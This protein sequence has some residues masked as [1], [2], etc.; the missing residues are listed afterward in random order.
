MQPS[1][2]CSP[3]TTPLRTT[4]LDLRAAIIIDEYDKP[5]QTFVKRHID[6]LFGGN[7]VVICRKPLE[8]A[9]PPGVFVYERPRIR[10]DTLMRPGD[11]AARI[12]AAAGLRK[13]LR[14]NGVNIVLA[15]FGYC[16]VAFYREAARF[17]IPMFCYFRGAD[18]SRWLTSPKYVGRL[19]DMAR[20]TEGMFAVSNFLLDNLRRHGV[21]HPNSHAVPSGVDTALFVPGEK[22]PNLVSSV[23][24]FI[25]KKGHRPTIKAFGRLAAKFPDLRLELVGDGEL[26]DDSRALAARLG[27][28]ERVIFHGYRDHAF[29]A[30]LL[31]RSTVYA[32]HSVTD[33]SGET[34][35]MPTSIQE[36]MAAGTAV[37]T[38]AHAGIPEYI[39]DGKSGFLVAEHD[40]DSYVERLEAVLSRP[41]L[42]ASM[43]ANARQCAVER[44]DFRICMRRIEDV[45][46][47]ALERRAGSPAV[48]W[49]AT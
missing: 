14:D 20:Q 41:D 26:L 48:L 4:G 18:A 47:Q 39:E 9:V 35:G 44:L 30:D 8:K 22:D 42:A 37:V 3:E 21:N 31:G 12:R 15:E 46:R 16:G 2:D 38:T 33:E 13:F 45:M 34:E 6:S 29:I 27:L 23:G 40:I 17:G 24:R 36:A 5:G 25:S 11:L 49:P 43:A 19:I 10:L 28:S 32:Q 7:T 1:S